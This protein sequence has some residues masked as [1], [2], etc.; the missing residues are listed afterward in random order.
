[1]ELVDGDSGHQLRD[2]SSLHFNSLLYFIVK[3]NNIFK[4][5][6][7]NNH[8]LNLKKKNF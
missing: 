8:K 6:S 7:K 4:K 2:L 1:M 3:N 5:G